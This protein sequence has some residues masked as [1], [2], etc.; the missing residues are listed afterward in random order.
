VDSRHVADLPP[1]ASS[2]TTVTG[3]CQGDQSSEERSS[4]E[5]HAAG[6][7]YLRLWSTAADTDRAG[8]KLDA[9]S[10]SVTP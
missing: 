4:Y 10:V 1:L 3:I 5:I 8:L 6:I 2:L 7:C 9:V